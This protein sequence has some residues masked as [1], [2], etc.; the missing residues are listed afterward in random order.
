MRE[1]SLFVLLLFQNNSP[2]QKKKSCYF[3]N[4]L[5]TSVYHFLDEYLNFL[6]EKW[7][8]RESGTIIL[9]QKGV[10]YTPGKTSLITL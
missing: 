10:T 8:E 6:F 1:V 5:R 4:K 2:L 9:K 7:E 3:L